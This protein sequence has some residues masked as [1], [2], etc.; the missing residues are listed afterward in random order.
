MPNWC[1]T[2]LVFEGDKQQIKTLYQTMKKLERR[3][4]PLVENDF[5]TNWLGCLVE[6]L[7]GQWK[8]IACRGTWYSLKCHGNTLRMETETAWGPCIETY[9]FI[10]K[11]FPSLTYYYRSEEPMMAKYLTN[12]RMGRYFKAGYYVDAVMP[13]GEY[14]SECFNGLE[15]ALRWLTEKSGC[16]IQSEADVEALNEQWHTDDN[17]GYCYLH[18][19]QVL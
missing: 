19:Y 1:N 6:A 8:E 5:G 17:E 10:C 16:T 2:S 14:V 18:R 12:D 9:S 3:K 7:G 11:V 13:N 4:T 15:E